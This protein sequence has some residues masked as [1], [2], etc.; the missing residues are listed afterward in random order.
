M[1]REELLGIVQPINAA[2]RLRAMMSPVRGVADVYVPFYLCRIHIAN[3]TRCETKLLAVDAVSGELDPYLIEE[4]ARFVNVRTR[5]VVPLVLGSDD[6]ARVAVEKVRRMIY[7]TSFFSLRDLT[8][9]AS[10]D[11]LLYVPYWLVLLG[12]ERDLA[13]RVFDAVRCR[14]E[15]AKM[16]AMLREWLVG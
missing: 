2:G 16:R 10:A 6:A 1:S 14:P 9:S 11:K 8:I 15:G 4:H 3:G 5:N 12:S 13:L 7:R